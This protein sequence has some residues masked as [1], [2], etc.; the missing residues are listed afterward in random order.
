MIDP[1]EYAE[2]LKNPPSLTSTDSARITEAGAFV[3]YATRK[4]SKGASILVLGAGDGH[5][6]VELEK[7]GYKKLMGISSHAGEA[8]GAVS[9]KLKITDLHDLF[10]KDKVDFVMSKETLEHVISPYVVLCKV[11]R[12]MQLGGKFCHLI[13][14]G[15]V[16]QR[17]WYHLNCAPP[18]MWVDWFTKTGFKVTKVERAIEQWAYHGEKIAEVGTFPAAAYDLEKLCHELNVPLV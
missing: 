18:W 11:N 17:D 16:K 8:K 10:L 14:S 3:S 4:L 9:D 15:P 13:P 5:E 12:S 6:L 1:T 2:Y 7:L